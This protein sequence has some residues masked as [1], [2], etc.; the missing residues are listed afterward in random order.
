MSAYLSFL[1]DT[2][3]MPDYTPGDINND[4]IINVNDVILTI[5]FILDLQ[6]PTEIEF[7]AADFNQDQV[8]DVLDVILIVNEILSE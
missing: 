1:L 7:L 3:F 8:I 6:E 2:E 4:G 5:R